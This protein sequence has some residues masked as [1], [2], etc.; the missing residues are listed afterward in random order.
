MKKIKYNVKGMSC[1]ACVAHVE[2]AAAKVCGEENVS[3]SL[4]T[5]SLTVTAE[6]SSNEEKLFLSLKKSLKGAGYALEKQEDGQKRQ[7]ISAEEFRKNLKRLIFSSVFTLL[8]MYVAMGHMLSLPLTHFLAENGVIFA[9]IQL[10]LALPVVIINFRFYRNGFAALARRAPNMDSL[11]AIGSAASLLYGCVAIGFMWHGYDAGELTL[12]EHYKHNLYF[13]SAAM[14]L[15]LVTLGKTLEGKAKANAASAVGKLA[16][17][18]PEEV[19]VLRDGQLCRLPIGEVAVGDIIAVKA[20]ETVPVDGEVVDGIGGVDESAISGESIPVEK[21]VGSKVKA[22]TTLTSGYLKIRAEKVGKDTSLAK[23]IGL[24]EDAAAS[25]APIA[26]IADK[27]SGIFVPVVM[28][29]S[30]LTAILWLVLAGD[31]EKAISCAI[32]VLVISCPC[33]LGLA[34]PTAIMVGTARGASRGLLIKSAEALENL[35]SVRFLLTDKTGTLTEGRPSVT[36]VVSASHGADEA[37]VL[38]VAYAAESVSSHPLAKAVCDEAIARGLSPIGE[39]LS[40][41]VKDVVGRGVRADIMGES[42]A[43][44]PCI[45]G[46]Y[47]FLVDNSV[48]V[49]R[50]TFAREKAEELE[51]Q[52]KTVVFVGFDGELVGVVAIADKP[53][54]DSREAVEALRRMGIETIMLTGDNQNTATAV[55][56]MCGIEESFSRLLPEEKE[57]YIRSYSEKGVCAMVGDGI[58]DAPALAAADIGIA[59]GAGTEAAIDCADVVLSGNSLCGVATAVSLSGATIT[60]IKQNLFWALFYNAVCIPIAAGALY[61]AFGILLS[62]MLASAAM[63][64]SSVFVVVNSLRLRGKRIYEGGSGSRGVKKA[65]RTK[66]ISINKKEN[67]DMFGKTKT[68]SF[69]VG[70]M[71]CNHCKANVEKALLAVKG[72]KSA[73]ADIDAKTVTVEVKESVGEAALKKAV[74]A[75]GYKV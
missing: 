63:S 21:S 24:L 4:L 27:V 48:N 38:S 68:V 75:A 50:E 66:N 49:S 46:K 33:A 67:K 70:G 47:E 73:V 72:V 13:E 61:P 54:E 71:M 69:E 30:L 53:R 39:V 60:T 58:N 62:P 45:V 43:E 26:R 2:H 55:A 9:L 64:F 15:T 57:E 8:L 74:A 10:C 14:I 51:K 25:K 29:I 34:T 56:E 42:G 22:V 40:H 52:G 19:N 17:M 12:V 5:N 16:A 18:M 36:D 11:I 32:A 44:Q 28:G 3:V 20:G 31:A 59:I 41:K 6:D 1:A 37:F 7:D 23:I 35:H 65:R